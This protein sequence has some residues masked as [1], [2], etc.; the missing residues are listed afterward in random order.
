MQQNNSISLLAFYS[1]SEQYNLSFDPNTPQNEPNF[2]TLGNISE[3]DKIEI[4]ERGF[5]LNQKGK[6]S[7]KEYYQGIAEYRLFELKGYQIKYESIRRT[8]LY[9]KLKG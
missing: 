5:Q 8:K 6:I 3:Q 2:V 7:L 4:I 9:L 1:N